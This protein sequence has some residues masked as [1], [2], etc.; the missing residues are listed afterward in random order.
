[1]RTAIKHTQGESMRRSIASGSDDTLKRLE[2]KG[3]SRRDFM[4]YCGAMAAVMGMEPAFAGR[5][6]YAL[7]APRRPS[8][9]YLHNAECTGCTEAFIRSTNPFPIDILFDVIS[10]DFHETLMD[11]SGHAAEAALDQ[12]LASPYG[13]HCVVEGAIPTAQNG[14]YGYAAGKTFLERGREMLPKAKAVIAYGTCASFGG[15]QAAAPNPTGAKGVNMCYAAEGVK[16]INISGCPPNPI[17]VVGALVALLTGETLE[18]D[19]YNRP[20]K[21]YGVTVHE[22]CERQPHFLAG[23]FAP[24]F[25]SEEA[26]RGWCLFKLGCRGPLTMN[27]CP[28]ALFNNTNWPVGAGHPCIGCSEPDFWDSMSPFYQE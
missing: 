27:N 24:A 3:I 28:K 18:L 5:I 20:L 2:K 7:T 15:V 1:M 8:I 4:K 10:L 16:A 17:N 11:A 13:F 12:A 25:D 23:R 19:R 9:I 26:R 22:Q 21:F 14:I 6:A